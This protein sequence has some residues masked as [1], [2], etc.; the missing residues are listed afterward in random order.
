MSPFYRPS[1]FAPKFGADAP[2]PLSGSTELS[3][4][5]LSAGVETQ[6]TTPSDIAKAHTF[7][8]PP[9]VDG[10][11]LAAPALTPG[12][13]EAALS[14]LPPPVP[15]ANEP[16][17][18]IIQL[19]M[20]MPGHLGIMS[21]FFEA[22]GHIFSPDLSFFGSLDPTLIAHQAHGA[23]DSLAAGGEH[24]AIDPSLLPADAP[25]F[26]NAGDHLAMSAD[27]GGL[28][29][30]S[31]TG[32]TSPSAS[33]HI[34]GTGMEC[35]GKY[36]VTNAHFEQAGQGEHM[37]SKSGL[38]SGPQMT[39]QAP[40]N[41]LSHEQRLFSDRM[42]GLPN[43][44][45][46][47][48]GQSAQSLPN[49]LNAGSNLLGQQANNLSSYGNAAVGQHYGPSGA[50]TDRLG[51]KPLLAESGSFDSATY[52]PVSSDSGSVGLKATQLTLP[53][54]KAP[55]NVVDH[56]GHQTKVGP[57]P[58]HSGV[59]EVAHRSLL[60]HGDHARAAH[61]GHHAEHGKMLKEADTPKP[62]ATEKI[63]QADAPETRDAAAGTYT[64]RSGDCLW[65]IANAHGLKWQDIYHLNSDVLGKNPA[66]IHPG[67]EIKLPAPGSDIASA[68]GDLAK[69]VVKPGDSLWKIADE[70]MGKGSRWG[71]I[72]H[73]NHAVVGSNPR[74]I[75]PGQE[76][77]I[78]ASGGE[79]I[80]SAASSA[81][82]VAAA[83][84]AA[85][86]STAYGGMP[87]GMMDNATSVPTTSA[88]QLAGPPGR[89]SSFGSES[90]AP[91]SLRPDINS[92]LNRQPRQ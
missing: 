14:A 44:Q 46:Q 41:Y 87:E 35:S 54:V 75:F 80:A 20:R 78:P 8:K 38:L 37:V 3:H 66:L 42:S 88:P 18:P 82:A 7:F 33:E 25:I 1:S 5:G 9:L 77:S 4:A 28:G 21:S 90:L 85:A 71:E 11:I 52:T 16:I 64:I 81:P 10:K 69:H 53:G 30:D 13:G 49:S 70:Y 27:H 63:A 92:L 48:A 57:H 36:D 39:G 26:Q 72:Y 86:P 62:E 47:L 34:T 84:P 56:I 68:G 51:G 43:G 24:L 40:G 76:L 67:V 60:N 23:L 15:G 58:S 32:L 12:A 29:L 83:P 17:S 45:S 89:M 65:S 50:V 31:S 74:L 59:D 22:L 79:H 2:T 19:I 91:S 55:H 6:L 61:S 73:L